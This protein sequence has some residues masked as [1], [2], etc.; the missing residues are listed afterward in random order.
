[1]NKV[2]QKVLEKMLTQT[3]ELWSNE[4]IK[5]CIFV[6]NLSECDYGE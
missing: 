4:L 2:D 1:M 6:M 5:P 3:S